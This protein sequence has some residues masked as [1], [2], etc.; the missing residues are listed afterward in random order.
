[1]GTVSRA[2]AF[3]SA[4][5]TPF[6]ALADPEGR[7]GWALMLMAGCGV[8]MTVFAAFALWIVRNNPNYA[9]YMGL[10]AHDQGQRTRQ[11]L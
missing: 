9:F 3:F 2:A 7:R 11:Q 4:L 6:R 1:V 5:A 10:A 8:S